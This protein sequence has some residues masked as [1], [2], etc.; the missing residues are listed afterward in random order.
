MR[1]LTQLDQLITV[2]RE[3]R[4]YALGHTDGALAMLAD[5]L[6]VPPDPGTPEHHSVF[7]K[8]FR[9]RVEWLDGPPE[10]HELAWLRYAIA[11]AAVRGREMPVGDA[12][13]DPSAQSPLA[14][15]GPRE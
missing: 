9:V 13:L 1:R 7:G 4:S 11:R 12:L 14:L 3:W 15:G 6:E 10:E 2:D 8:A 5:A